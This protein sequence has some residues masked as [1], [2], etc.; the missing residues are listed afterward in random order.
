ME[1]GCPD[2]ESPQEVAAVPPQA[3]ARHHHLGAQG[4]QD[5]EV[6]VAQVDPHQLVLT[7]EHLR[8]QPFQAMEVQVH[9]L[10]LVTVH[11]QVV[12]HHHQVIGLLQ[13]VIQPPLDI[14][15]LQVV[16]QPPLGIVLLLE[17]VQP[18]LAMGLLQ[19]VV[20]PP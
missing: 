4:C 13:V 1:E 19:V 10:L 12:A 6:E 18:P 9:L 5:M 14:L 15:P 20:Q 3:T 17:V 8:L 11:H 7:M 2:M 16:V